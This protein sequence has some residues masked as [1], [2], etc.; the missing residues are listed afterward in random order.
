MLICYTSSSLQLW[1]ETK[2]GRNLFCV[3][4]SNHFPILLKPLNQMH[5][6]LS[7]QNAVIKLHNLWGFFFPE[8]KYFSH[9]LQFSSL[10]GCPSYFYFDRYFFGRALHLLILHSVSVIRE[11]LSAS[12]RE[13][14]SPSKLIHFQSSSISNSPTQIDLNLWKVKGF[15]CIHISLLKFCVVRNMTQN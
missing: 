14:V 15:K 4:S 3:G 13:K 11:L 2:R 9:L 6:K 7:H 10:P 12:L 1:Q 5:L 8:E